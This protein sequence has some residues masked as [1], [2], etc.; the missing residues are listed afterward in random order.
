MNWIDIAIVVVWGISAFWGFSTGFLQVVVPLASM[1]VGLALASRIGDSVGNVFSS[2]T[3]NE[4]AQS[5]AG[6]M[7]IFGL[8]FILGAIISH[9]G[10]TLLRIIPLAGLVNSI[11]GMAAGLLVG[12]LL[13]SG[14][15]TGIQRFPFRDLDQTIDD[16]ALG[17]FLADNFDM[18]IRGVRLIPG[19]W[20]NQLRNL[21]N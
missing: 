1:V 7:L 13:L 15:L 19:D 8:I 4:N 9:L 12:F 11:A 2:F 18:V 5:V 16:S 3:G 10:R 17:S 6:F 21:T 20:D 14:V